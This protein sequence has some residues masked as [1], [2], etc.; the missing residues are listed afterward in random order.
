MR[1]DTAL[2]SKEKVEA[3]KDELLHPRETLW[4]SPKTQPQSSARLSASFLPHRW[5]TRPGRQS[6]LTTCVA[7]ANMTGMSNKLRERERVLR[8]SNALFFDLR[9]NWQKGKKKRKRRGDKR[10]HVAAA[11]EP[12]LYF[13]LLFDEQ[14]YF[15]NR[16][17]RPL[18]LSSVTQLAQP[19][20]VASAR[21][22]M[23]MYAR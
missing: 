10:W 7:A 13:S 11:T 22:E 15:A 14:R 23:V 6:Q 3:S 8:L 9:A 16:N 1:S 4:R 5:L 20:A 17:W 2:R 19:C 21:I 12:D 18:P